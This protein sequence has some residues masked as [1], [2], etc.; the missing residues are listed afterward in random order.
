MEF[1]DVNFEMDGSVQFESSE[2]SRDPECD[3][4]FR[5]GVADLYLLA[6]GGTIVT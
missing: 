3:P 6:G 2:P 1:G 4:P 5:T